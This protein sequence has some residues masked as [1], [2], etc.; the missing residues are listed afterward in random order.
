MLLLT[1]LLPPL[2]ISLPQSLS[3]LSHLPSHIR[4]AFEHLR[5][6]N[7]PIAPID[8]IV[9][10]EGIP[11][12][13]PE[14]IVDPILPE[15]LKPAY[16]PLIFTGRD[17]WQAF[18]EDPAGAWETGDREH[19]W[20]FW[21]SGVQVDE[22]GSVGPP[23]IEGTE[24]PAL[25]E[26]VGR[27][28]E[29]RRRKLEVGMFLS[30]QNDEV[31]RDTAI[32]IS[33]HQQREQFE[34]S[35]SST[36]AGTKTSSVDPIFSSESPVAP[37]SSY[38]HFAFVNC[39]DEE[40]RPLCYR[41]LAVK[42]HRQ[43]LYVI[44]RNTTTIEP[45]PESAKD[46]EPEVPSVVP[47]FVH[48]E[49]HDSGVT[50]QLGDDAVVHIGTEKEK[51]M[52]EDP[53]EGAVD[54]EPP[55]PLQPTIIHK[56]ILRR[57]PLKLNLTTTDL[58]NFYEFQRWEK[59]PVW[60]DALNP[61][62]G[63][64]GTAM[65]GKVGE[66]I[67]IGYEYWHKTPQWVF[68]VVLALLL[69]WI[70]VSI[71]EKGNEK[72]QMKGAKRE[73]KLTEVAAVAAAEAA[74]IP[75]KAQ[76]ILPEVPEKPEIP[77]EAQVPEEIE[78]VEHAE[79]AKAEEVASIAEVLDKF[80]VRPEIKPELR[81]DGGDEVEEKVETSGEASSEA[82]GEASAGTNGGTNGNTKDPVRGG[83]QVPRLEDKASMEDL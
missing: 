11:E 37:P 31:Y 52:N 6:T 32:A 27:E 19:I 14:P 44:T 56:L 25:V 10:V 34:Q 69:R 64:I 17:A 12:L 45:T 68:W 66:L 3:K 63:L 67:G 75:L 76:V 40:E 38:A 29:V 70:T 80:D 8:S 55:Q 4:S 26:G 58:H 41:F 16:A 42:E 36:S 59:L 33:K 72:R 54:V 1:L 35:V 30:D 49:E 82:S 20:F 81:G 7:P 48:T 77:M 61:A 71:L 46:A 39:N 74:Q 51:A 28:F 78:V 2:I 53:V 22:E 65:E 5:S 73:S 9:P 47:E 60:D 21:F 57:V 13:I 83:N 79:L 43:M 23:L 24:W 50:Q 15:P 62:D 18:S